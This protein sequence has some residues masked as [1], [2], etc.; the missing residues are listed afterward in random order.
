MPFVAAAFI[1]VI[2]VVVILQ[3]RR[4]SE[5]QALILGGSVLPGCAVVQG[6]V[7]IAIAIAIV[8]FG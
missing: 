1:A 3:R 2:G 6:V 7:L 8:A 5:A 4:L